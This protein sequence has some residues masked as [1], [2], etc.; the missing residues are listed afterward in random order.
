MQL[1]LLPLYTSKKFHQLYNLQSEPLTSSI[2]YA[3]IVRRTNRGEKGWINI[4]VN[5]NGFKVFKFPWWIKR[6]W[7]IKRERI[8]W[9]W[10]YTNPYQFGC[11]D[12]Q[13]C[14]LWDGY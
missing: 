7:R 11:I 3:E 5:G 12:S 9:V 8:K 13:Q 10:L 6:K 1:N 2:K 4:G 14:S